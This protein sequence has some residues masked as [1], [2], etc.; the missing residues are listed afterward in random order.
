MLEPTGPTWSWHKPASDL[1]GQQACVTS[2]THALPSAKVIITFALSCNIY[3]WNRGEWF[4][5]AKMKTKVSIR[6]SAGEYSPL[7]LPFSLFPF[8]LVFLFVG[9]FYLLSTL[10]WFPLLFVF[11][12]FFPVF[13]FFSPWP[14][15]SYSLAFYWGRTNW[16][17]PST[18]LLSLAEEKSCGDL[19]TL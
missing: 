3:I 17:F 10:L 6:A 18:P 11:S 7:S 5:L 13:C 1:A 16:L 2:V 9:F 12:A 19:D 8:V 14:F 4:Y 15:S